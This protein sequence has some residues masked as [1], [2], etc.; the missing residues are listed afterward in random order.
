LALFA[1]GACWLLF[2]DELRDEWQLN[3]QYGFG[4]LVPLLTAVLVW[5]RWPERP[6]VPA[7]QPP[8]TGPL[9]VAVAAALL[10][11]L[12]PLRVTLE[13]NPEWRLLYWLHGF[14]M[15]AL[16]LVLLHWVGGWNWVRFF[17]PPILFVLI[18]VPWPMQLEQFC[19]QGLMRLVAGLT[20]SIADLL[21][22]PAVQHGNL[23]EVDAGMVGIDEACSGVRSLQS[24]LMLSL[25]LGEMYRFTLARRAA[26]C[27]PI[28]R[29]RLSSSGPRPRAASARWRPGMIPPA[30]WS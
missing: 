21:G 25:F 30:I 7:S 3:P 14:Q 1:L 18:A 22:I 10:L 29:A 4:Y 17:L 8:A 6:P 24:A 11:L 26:L 5:R 20:V 2:F 16:T 9:A 27:L 15:V 28:S 13:A 12:L 23:V 19:I